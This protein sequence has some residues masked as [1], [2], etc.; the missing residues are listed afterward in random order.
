MLSSD[1]DFPPPLDFKS[2]AMKTQTLTTLAALLAAAL[3]SA[4]TPARAEEEPWLKARPEI[5]KEWDD[6]TFG[7]F[8]HWD[9]S[10]LLGVEISWHRKSPM[11][12]PIPD[13]VYDN[14]YRSFYPGSFDAKEI[15]RIVKEAGM[16]YIVFTTKHHGGFCMFD[17]AL[18]DYD[19]MGSPFKRDIVRELAEATREAGLVFGIYYSQPDWHNAD[20]MAKNWEEYNKYFHG[21]MRELCTN[22]GKIG[23]IFF[24]GISYGSTQYRPKD[25]FK[26]IREL[27]PD[28]VINNRCGLPGDYDTPEQ[29][30]GAFK[31]DRPWETC[32]TLGTSWSWKTHDK[33][34]SAKE[35][36][37]LLVM[38]VGSGGNL[39]L[40]VGPMPT[41]EIEPRQAAVLKEVGNWLKTNGSAVYGLRGGPFKPGAWGASVHNDHTIFL[42]ILS[43][44]DVPA[45]FPPPGANIASVT[46][47]DGRPVRFAQNEK[48]FSIDVPG[49]ER[50]PVDTILRLTLAG[51]APAAAQLK[52]LLVPTR[53][54]ARMQSATA[55]HVPEQAR[56]L[57]DD[58][59]GTQWVPGEKK[60][61]AEIDLGKDQNFRRVEI[62][63]EGHPWE[64]RTSDFEL[65][66]RA[67]NSAPEAWQTLDKGTSI[68]STYSKSF[69]PVTARYLRLKINDSGALPRFSEI[70]VYNY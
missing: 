21:Q 35:V 44:N 62:R 32:M 8:I 15:A 2:F 26:M 60:C 7:M 56:H 46:R 70:Q 68:G 55:S 12:G 4:P 61:W 39:L 41:G 47:L 22:H 3:A 10:S 23:M 9:P 66:A 48:G 43:W 34:K 36:I 17:S 24:D 14:L 50:D 40:N 5:M 57:V 6:L 13:G 69:A 11:N 45:L 58:D 28:V 33:I 38:T 19:I 18:T 20:F 27:Q 52:P 37:R 59:P 53:S 25:L 30:V 29:V 1:P 54:L 42:H 51:D 67:A 49:A 64:R 65:L 31:T 63:E 16:R